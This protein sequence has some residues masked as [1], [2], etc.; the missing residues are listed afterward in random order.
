MS[1]GEGR[2]LR[3]T[4]ESVKGCNI[5][6]HGPRRLPSFSRPFSCRRRGEEFR[7]ISGIRRRGSG[8]D[9]GSFSRPS[10][11]RATLSPARETASARRF[12]REVKGAGSE[13]RL[14][15]FRKGCLR[16]FHGDRH[17][18]ICMSR[19]ARQGLSFII[20][21]VNRR[22]TDI[23]KCIR[24]MLQRRLSRCGRSIRE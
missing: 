6:L 10:C 19:R 5:G 14:S 11:R 20:Q 22:K 15:R 24:R 21:E 7:P 3:R 1:R 8:R 12:R 2:H 13:G 23:S 17:G 18:T 16:P 4:V 9:G